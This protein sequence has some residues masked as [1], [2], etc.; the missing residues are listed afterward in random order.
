MV[1]YSQNVLLAIVV[2][3]LQLAKPAIHITILLICLVIYRNASPVIT[4]LLVYLTFI[5]V[6]REMNYVSIN[7]EVV[8]TKASNFRNQ[9]T[10]LD[11]VLN[12]GVVCPDLSRKE[13]HRYVGGGRMV[14]AGSVG[15]LLQDPT[16]AK[17]PLVCSH[18]HYC[19]SDASTL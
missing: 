2:G 5:F 11:L 14:T 3:L 4:A 10:C 12:I 18:P 17:Y 16:K 13:L 8:H 9:N 6:W 19:A 15:G 1:S 7:C